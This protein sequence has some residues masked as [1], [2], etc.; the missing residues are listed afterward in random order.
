MNINAIIAYENGE[1]E[2]SD[3]LDLFQALVN[4]GTA[5]QLQGHYGRTAQALLDQGLIQPASA[6]VRCFRIKFSD[7]DGDVWDVKA[8]IS[9]SERAWLRNLYREGRELRPDHG[10]ENEKHELLSA[11]FGDN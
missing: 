11:Y 6:D 9:R 5:W 1:L 4:D 2:G 3:V 7:L 10:A 8:H